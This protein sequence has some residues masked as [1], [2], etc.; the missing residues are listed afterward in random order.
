MNRSLPL[1]SLLEDSYM[2]FLILAEDELVVIIT[3]SSVGPYV[4]L[5]N[6]LSD[7]GH[8]HYVYLNIFISS[9]QLLNWTTI[10]FLILLIY[11]VQTHLY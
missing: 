9:K 1:E 3:D 4:D 11:C 6:M 2:L 10:S 5:K 8:Q 7:M